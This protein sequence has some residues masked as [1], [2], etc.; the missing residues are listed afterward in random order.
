MSR[1]FLV[2]LSALNGWFFVSFLRDLIYWPDDHPLDRNSFA[3]LVLFAA[4]T[5]APIVG[6]FII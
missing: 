3:A 2:A 1:L 5:V 4:L 6:L